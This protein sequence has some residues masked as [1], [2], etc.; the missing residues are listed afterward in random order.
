MLFVHWL[1]TQQGNNA[2]LVN[3]FFGI[4]TF[5]SEDQRANNVL[6]KLSRMMTGQ[7]LSHDRALKM[8]GKR[9]ETHVYWLLL[10]W[11]RWVAMGRLP[12]F[13]LPGEGGTLANPYPT[14]RRIR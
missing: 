6:I 3:R 4:I 1:L 2:E 8:T 10:N 14:L 12:S 5:G 11:N 7:D 9:Q 13:T